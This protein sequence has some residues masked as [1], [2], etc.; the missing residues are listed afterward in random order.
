MLV[1][2]FVQLFKAFLDFFGGVVSYDLP[3]LLLAECQLIAN[4]VLLNP[5]SNLRHHA[6]E[7]HLPEK[8]KKPSKKQKNAFKIDQI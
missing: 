1:N 3:Q 4:F 8:Q 5:P 7:K 6:F 2:F